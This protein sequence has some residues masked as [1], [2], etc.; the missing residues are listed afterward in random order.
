MIKRTS[1]RRVRV[2][3]IRRISFSWSKPQ[4]LGLKRQGQVADLVQKEAAAVGLFDQ[5]GLVPEGPGERPAGM[6]EKLALQEMVGNGPAVDGDERAPASLPAVMD[7]P[8]DELL[9]RA[10]LAVDKHRRRCVLDLGDERPDGLGGR[11]SA[12][13]RLAGGGGRRTG[14]GEPLD[15]VLSD[16]GQ[17]RT[18]QE[19]ASLEVLRRKWGGSAVAGEANG[20]DRAKTD[21]ERQAEQALPGTAASAAAVTRGRF[22]STD[23]RIRPAARSSNDLSGAGHACSKAVPPFPSPTASR[24]REARVSR[25]ARSRSLDRCSRIWASLIPTPD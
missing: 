1:I 15:E 5:P 3:P 21:D 2:S 17:H 23:F 4:E 24:P 14:R 13:D 9:A 19:M 11:A 22:S 8:G 10:A 6:A 12:D 20:P 18:A 25:P 16:D 7:G